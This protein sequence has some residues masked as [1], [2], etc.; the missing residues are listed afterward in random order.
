MT[1]NAFVRFFKTYTTVMTN[2]NK[3]EWFEI[4]ATPII[5]ATLSL[6]IE[7][8]SAYENLKAK[9]MKYK[10]ERK[11]GSKFTL[12]L[13]HIKGIERD[14]SDHIFLL[15]GKTEVT[16]NDKKGDILLSYDEFA[17]KKTK[18]FRSNHLTISK[19]KN[20]V[21]IK[22]SVKDKEDTSLYNVYIF[23]I[24]KLDAKGVEDII[25]IIKEYAN[26]YERRIVD[27]SNVLSIIKS[28]LMKLYKI[29]GE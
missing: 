22:V 4:I 2:L 21:F 11:I 14:L 6:R 28:T 1:S 12:K 7:L 27:E 13:V 24:D 9:I 18:V 19:N 20:R 10:E 16:D 8:P 26:K 25:S 3:K 15:N 29:K 5:L 17:T 23:E